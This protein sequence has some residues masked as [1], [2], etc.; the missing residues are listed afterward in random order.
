[1]EY[2]RGS[3]VPG[4]Q[5]SQAKIVAK[6]A[7]APPPVP[8]A[9]LKPEKVQRTFA[10][11]VDDLGL[12][13][14]SMAHVRDALNNFVDAQMQPG[15]LVAILRTSAGMG[16][17]QQ[18]TND[19]RLL[20]A[21]IDR[22]KFN[23]L[24]RTGVFT[25]APYVPPP[26]APPG[27]KL[28]TPD[29][30]PDHQSDLFRIGTLGAISYIIDGLREL[31][32]RKSVVL[33]SENMDVTTLPGNASEATKHIRDLID[34]ANRASVVIDTID[35]RG[36]MP[37]FV[38]SADD[39]KAG[40]VAP[41]QQLRATQ[42]FDSQTGLGVLAEETGG[43]FIK[44]DNLV[45]NAMQLVLDDSNGYYLIAYRPN[46]A[47]FDPETGAAKFHKTVLRVKTPGLHVRTRSGFL[48]VSD[49]ARNAAPRTVEDKLRHALASPFAAG[50]VQVRLT[51][52]FSNTAQQGSFLRALLYIDPKDLR[53]FEM[54]DGSHDARIDILL[55]TFGDAGKAIDSIHRNWSI[56]ADAA[57]FSDLLSHG[58]ICSL[59]YPVKKGGAYQMRA[60][61]VDAFSDKVG[62]AS[63]FIEIPDVSKNGLTLSSIFL[64]NQT[65]EADRVFNPGA[66]VD[67]EY[68]IFNARMDA[69]NRPDIEIETKIFRD[70]KEV[71]SGK[72]MA[73]GKAD[74]SD[75]VRVRAGGHLQLASQLAAGDYVL[76]VIV[77]DKLADPKGRVA[78]QWIDFEVVR[79]SRL[80]E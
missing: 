57:G 56:H 5:Q 55:T 1:M 59:N 7:L 21:A 67:Y 49:T 69:G 20:H 40:H 80:P 54:P 66:P 51:T 42:R 36:L 79:P 23:M 26:D 34:A 10:M 73:L 8:P 37:A 31:P 35:P 16:A 77:T 46:S 15:D 63:Q 47:T 48:G 2:I 25:I 38:S 71:Y 19:K 58:V 32:G 3:A 30:T 68:Q 6:G 72:P 70:G 78:S 41:L 50:G 61:V 33:F 65:R 43:L 14:E 22:I 62:T 45:D 27:F 11:V 76:Q 60:A 17:F 13:V 64:G 12:S 52:A 44:N 53:F 28:L 4:V 75:P 29:R 74:F 18:F 24:S 39:V 9:T